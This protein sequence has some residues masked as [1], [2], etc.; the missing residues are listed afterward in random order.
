MTIHRQLGGLPLCCD[1]FGSARLCFE[2][3]PALTSKE[4]ALL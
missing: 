2:A 1:L 4:A 3:V